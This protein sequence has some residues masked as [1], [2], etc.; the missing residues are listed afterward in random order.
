MSHAIYTASAEAF[1]ASLGSLAAILAQAAQREDAAKLPAERLYPDMFP[2]STQVQLA[3]F[4]ASSGTAR[5]MG[6]EVVGRP[7]IQELDLPSL[8]ALAE[9]TQKSL[10]ALTATEFAGAEERR[11][12][13]PLQPP[14]VLDID[15]VNFLH[16]WLVPNFYFHYVTAYDILRHKG[17][18]I[19][20]RDYL[21]HLAR[22]MTQTA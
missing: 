11:I 20:K 9:G 12:N 18:A 19:G 13:M 21:A 3:C 5:L 14:M 7:A 6:H 17:L 8:Q 2:L 16:S 15:G 1:A 4:H 10:A 22:F